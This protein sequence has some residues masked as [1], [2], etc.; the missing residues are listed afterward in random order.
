M[1][2]AICRNRRRSIGLPTDVVAE[3]QQALQQGSRIG[4][5]T[6]STRNKGQPEAACEACAL[7]FR[8]TVLALGRISHY[9]GWF[10]RGL[11]ATIHLSAKK[12]ASPTCFGRT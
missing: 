1:R 12:P 2:G 4:A 5:A 7:T 10:W 8:Q 11:L 3:A 9:E 6:P